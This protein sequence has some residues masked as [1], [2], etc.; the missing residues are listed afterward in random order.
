MR[1]VSYHQSV[2]DLLD[3]RPA[4]SAQAREMIEACERRC[5]RRLP[6]SV[7][8]WYLVEGVVAL[9]YD[10]DW[11]APASSQKSYLWYDYSNM[12]LPE[13]VEAVLGQFADGRTQASEEEYGPPAAPAGSVPVM[14]ENSGACRWYVQPNGSADPPVIV[15]ETYDFQAKQV[16]LWKRVADCFSAFVFD[17]FARFYQQD[18]IPLSGRS[19]YTQQRTRP[20]GDK[21]YL[22]GLWL[23]ASKGEA[24]APPYIDYL[25]ESFAEDSREEVAAGVM[26]HCFHDEHGRLRVTT[27]GPREE[28]GVSAWWLHAGSEEDLFR[29]ARKVWWC[30]DLPMTL[31]HGSETAEGVLARL[32]TA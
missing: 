27:D 16:V 15:D 20:E 31:R 24:V 10:A 28:G 2:F 3:I 7:R 12:D 23:Y 1:R 8:Q 22:N 9:H 21:P 30:C 11:H 14:L 5:G 29:L 26:Q 13:S 4:E 6:E 32:R 17:W 25:I 18:W 19:P